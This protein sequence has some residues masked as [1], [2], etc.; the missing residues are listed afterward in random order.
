M[1]IL[2][3]IKEVFNYYVLNMPGKYGMRKRYIK[4]KDL[5]A[6]CGNNIYIGQN[7]A[8]LGFENISIGNRINIMSNSYVYAH[9]GGK[10][11][12]G[13][14]FSINNGVYI[15]ASG[16][17]IIIG[18]NVCIGPYTVL[19]ALDHG[20]DRVDIPMT[21]QKDIGGE[22]IIED[23]VWIGANCTILKDVR[24]GTGSIVAAGCVVT[25]NVLPYTIVGGVPNKVIK[26]RM[27]DGK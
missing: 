1:R 6:S 2:D 13:D 11:S 24:I 19:R 17:K 9:A 3:E 23:D 5:F 8:I 16:G 12:V 22:I 18:D 15:G 10:L 14:D 26:N 20:H 25:K 27:D 4:Y 21:K 7:V